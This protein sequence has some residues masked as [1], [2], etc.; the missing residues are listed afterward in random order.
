WWGGEAVNRIVVAAAVLGLLA[1]SGRAAAQVP[2]PTPF[3]PRLGGATAPPFSPYL[4]LT[5]PGGSPTLNYSGLVRP[6]L[7]NRAAAQGLQRAPPRCAGPE[8]GLRPAPC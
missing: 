1:V 4:N 5:R 3:G 7:Q 8:A 2:A 6:E